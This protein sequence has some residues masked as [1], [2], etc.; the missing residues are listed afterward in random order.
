M[1]K[2][3]LDAELRAK[4]DG[5]TD[6]VELTDE[7]GNV[8]GR[9]VPEGRSYVTDAVYDRIMS[10][11]LPPLSREELDEARKEMLEHGGVSTAE[12]IA[13]IE[14]GIRRSEARQK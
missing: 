14:N 1:S 11:L 2:V 3:V 9:Y 10:A 5:A 4:L 6:T 12:I 7:A 8:I 13:A